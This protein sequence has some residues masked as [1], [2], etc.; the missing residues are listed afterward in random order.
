M[1][2]NVPP[3]FE[4][5]TRHANSNVCIG[6]HPGPE[7]QV[8]DFFRAELFKCFFKDLLILFHNQPNKSWILSRLIEYADSFITM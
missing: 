7:T 6:W 5:F 2:P 8:F 4:W 3:T 1:D